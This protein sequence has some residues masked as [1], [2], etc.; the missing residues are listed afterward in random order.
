MNETKSTPAPEAGSAM[1]IWV[2]VRTR[3]CGWQ[4]L[5]TQLIDVR[6][7]RFTRLPTY[8]GTCPGCGGKVFYVRQSPNAKGSATPEDAR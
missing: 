6:D 1:E 8:T 4:G 3:K 7:H 2:C 5:S